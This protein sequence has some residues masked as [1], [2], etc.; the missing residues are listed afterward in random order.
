MS[1]WVRLVS[2]FAPRAHPPTPTIKSSH[3]DL[4]NSELLCLEVPLY[5]LSTAGQTLDRIR[6]QEKGTFGHLKPLSLCG[7]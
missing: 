4:I 1:V 3:A 5:F 2:L 6:S 7:L